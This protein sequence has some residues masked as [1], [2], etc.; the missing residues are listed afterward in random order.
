MVQ[1]WDRF[2]LCMNFLIFP[3]FGALYAFYSKI[4]CRM[5]IEKYMI[6]IFGFLSLFSYKI[7]RKILSDLRE[8]PLYQ[9]R[10]SMSTCAIKA[11]AQNTF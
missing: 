2:G 3:S 8:K 10:K 7:V 11:I 1:I 5:Q 6:V 4:T 9:L